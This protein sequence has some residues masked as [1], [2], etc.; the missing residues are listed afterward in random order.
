M[1]NAIVLFLLALA[2]SGV[3]AQ[4]P[5]WT[6]DDFT[7]TYSAKV[8]IAKGE[9]RLELRRL[10]DERF[11]VES[12]TKLRGLVSLFK[13]GEIYEVAHFD[14]VDG[15]LLTRDFERRDNI[16]GEDRNV[17]VTYDWDKQT[18]AVVY[19]DNTT[20]VAIETGVSNTLVMQVALMQHL[21]SAQRPEW[22]DVVGHKGRLR[23]NIRYEGEEISDD[24]QFGKALVRYSHSREASDIRT[25]FWAAPQRDHLPLKAEIMKAEKV[26]GQLTLV[27]RDVSAS[28]SAD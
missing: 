14:Y 17:R 28:R 7:A 5:A 19:Q 23:F 20:S 4:T 21:S 24:D 6:V 3:S 13:R 15:E 26:K 11:V 10:D 12:W 2:C 16:S 25:T 8:G 9:T 18:A 1:K 27:S 22:L